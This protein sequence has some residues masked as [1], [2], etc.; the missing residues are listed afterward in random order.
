MGTS[1]NYDAP[2]KWGSL[3]GSATRTGGQ[4]LSPAN[5]AKFVRDHIGNNGG[6]HRIAAS[7][8]VL[9]AGRTPQQVARSFAGFVSQVR[10]AGLAEAL[11]QIGLQ[12]LI[13]RPANELLLGIV[14]RCGGTNGTI[15][16]ADARSALARLMEEVLEQA[17]TPGEVE[18]ILNENAIGTALADLLMNFFKFYIYEQFCRVFFE[19][20]VK[21]HGEQRAESFLGDILE[22]VHAA[23]RNRTLGIDVASIEWLG[24]EGEQIT[25]SIMQLTLEVFE[26]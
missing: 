10:D 22:F 15:D 11:R 7:G 9:G 6:S 19:H 8:G 13:G 2:P 3:K 5:A 24:P 20:L 17:E 14:N 16:A 23:L 25:S 12:D 26:R 21:K 1:K 18:A 4:R